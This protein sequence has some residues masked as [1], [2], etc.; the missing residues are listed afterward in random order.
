MVN[1]EDN[2][3]VPFNRSRNELNCFEAVGA[4]KNASDYP[5]LL[6]NSVVVEE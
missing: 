5:S 3:R 4:L 2:K 1:I 6:I